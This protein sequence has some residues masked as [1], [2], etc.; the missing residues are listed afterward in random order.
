MGRQDMSVVREQERRQRAAEP[1]V[2]QIGNRM[3]ED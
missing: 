1:G 2:D 3:F